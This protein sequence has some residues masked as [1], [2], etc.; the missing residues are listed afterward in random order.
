M[1]LSP[2]SNAGQNHDIKIANKSFENVEISNQNLMQE[3]IKRR[4]NLGMC[5][6]IQSR[7]FCLSKNI[8]IR[9]HETIIL[10][11][12]LYGCETL[13]EEY[14]LRESENRLLR[15]CGPKRDDVAG[16]WRRLHNEELHN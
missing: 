1:L 8:K 3:K 2:H 13:Q 5:A 6:T 10:S 14:R 16:V 15:I 7:T 4:L 11:V 12:I 9:I